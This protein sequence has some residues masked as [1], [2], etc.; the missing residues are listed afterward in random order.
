MTK[1]IKLSEI[2]E[3]I[4]KNGL[5]QTHGAYFRMGDKKSFSTLNPNVAVYACALGQAGANLNVEPN[6]LL[7]ELNVKGPVINGHQLGYRITSWNDELKYKFPTI[8]GRLDK[9]VEKHGDIVFTVYD[10]NEEV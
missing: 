8:A 4:R 1:T 6:E 5:K 9:V 7:H 2:A 10:E 3:A